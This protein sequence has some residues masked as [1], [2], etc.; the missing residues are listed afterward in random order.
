MNV[1]DF[2]YKIKPV[3]L[4]VIPIIANIINY[5]TGAWTDSNGQ[6]VNL[7]WSKKTYVLL[8][9]IVHIVIVIVYTICESKDNKD[10]QNYEGEITKRDIK[11]EAYRKE[12]SSLTNAFDVSQKAINKLTK[13]LIADKQL[14][15]REWNFEA[16]STYICKGVYNSIATVAT[17]GTNFTVNIYLK[18]EEE[19]KQYVTMIA[20]E[21]EFKSQ[22]KIFGIRK[23]LKGTGEYYYEK[24]FINNNPEISILVDKDSV[25]KAFK[26]NGDYEKYKDEYNQYV[27]IP[28]SCNGN[29]IIALLEI[30]AHKDSVIANKQEEIR[31]IVNHYVI[32][33][34]YF[35]LLAHKIEKNMKASAKM[36]KVEV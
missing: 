7:F 20:H 18:E 5:I 21:G 34:Q 29:N 10:R 12:V 19:K 1:K 17:N 36:I 4:V 3:V 32:S 30:I 14:D 15:L 11:L 22:P 13:H 23:L 8:F 28:I 25:K 9:L 24:Q 35:A 27:G 26:F 16:I 2:F 31:D 6:M 33:Y